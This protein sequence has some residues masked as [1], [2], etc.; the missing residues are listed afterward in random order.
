MAV[1]SSAIDTVKKGKADASGTVELIGLAQAAFTGLGTGTVQ[2]SGVISL[3]VATW[4]AMAGTTGGLAYGVV[5]YL[6]PTTAG[7][8][9]STAPTIA[10]K[11]VVRIGRAISTLELVIH[12]EQPILL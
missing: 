7:N 5:Y 1:Y 8:I 9:T 12:I 3:A 10:G 6:D 4:D 11:Y 2:S